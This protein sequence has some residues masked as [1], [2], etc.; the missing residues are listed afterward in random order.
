MMLIFI[1][2]GKMSSKLTWIVES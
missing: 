2:E 1:S